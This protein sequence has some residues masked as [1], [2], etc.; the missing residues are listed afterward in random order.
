MKIQNRFSKIHDPR[1]LQIFAWFTDSTSSKLM[2]K[3]DAAPSISDFVIFKAISSGAYG[4]VM[5]G[6][7]KNNTDQIYAIKIVSKSAMLEKN[8][9]DQVTAERNALAISNCPYIVHLYY[10]LQTD[11][12][13]YLVMEYLIGGDLKSLI[14]LCGYLS[15]LHAA[16]YMAEM[17]I[18]VK[19]LHGNGIIHRDLK[20]DNVLITAKGHLKLTDF[21]LSTV[22][23]PRDLNPHD[24]MNT[25]S[26]SIDPQGHLR[27]P[28][29]IISLTERLSFNHCTSIYESENDTLAHHSSSKKALLCSTPGGDNTSQNPNDVGMCHAVKV[30]TS[31]KTPSVPPQ[32]NNPASD[33][34]SLIISLSRFGLCKR[35]SSVELSNAVCL[36]ELNP[37][38][39]HHHHHH[40]R[41]LRTPQTEMRPRPLRSPM[42]LSRHARST[43]SRSDRRV[44]QG[45]DVSNGIRRSRIGRGNLFA[46]YETSTSTVI[47]DSRL[48]KDS[49][50]EGDSV[51]EPPTDTIP[52]PP[53]QNMDVSPPL[54]PPTLLLTPCHEVEEEFL[55]PFNSTFIHDVEEPMEKGDNEEGDEMRWVEDEKTRLDASLKTEQDEPLLGT[56]EYLA[57]ELLFPG[58]SHAAAIASPA[59]DWWALGV[60]LFEMI[61]GVSPF[62]DLTVPDI[63]AHITNLEIPWPET[64]T[65][66][67]KGNVASVVTNEEDQQFVGIS[68]ESKDLIGCLLVREPMQRIETAARMET[69]PFFVQVGPWRDLPNV[70]MPFIPCPDDNTDT[71][72]FE[73]RNRI[74]P[75]KVTDSGCKL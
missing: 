35:L 2:S 53:P 49:S 12:Y 26:A 71:F 42:F 59:V 37:A 8:L 32:Q 70:T 67:K 48:L 51:Y 55:A 15:E 44:M 38:H 50:R 36:S 16:L 72:Y 29:Q 33:M 17:S 74:R 22:R 3:D 62:A 21:G 24:L 9:V 31:F 58:S 18:A 66:D 56:P 13:I 23:L 11:Q 34:S 19:Y 61:T 47:N 43:I 28:G 39:L 27:T 75:W 65:E 73:P 30:G 64:L 54:L 20:P 1:L 68:P 4:K 46:D 40:S 52:F 25:P 14:L 57:P 6:A 45:C 63:F 60:I 69:H 41:I 7:K 5:L 10:S